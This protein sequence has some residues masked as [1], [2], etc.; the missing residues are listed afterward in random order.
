MAKRMQLTHP[1][2]AGKV[3]HGTKRFSRITKAPGIPR[4]YVS[5]HCLIGGPEL[6][7]GATKEEA[8]LRLDKVRTRGVVAPLRVAEL[9]ECPGIVDRLVARPA[10]VPSHFRITCI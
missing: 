2:S 3:D 10:Q 1:E 9:D 8:R 7:P 6:E 5:G 4:E